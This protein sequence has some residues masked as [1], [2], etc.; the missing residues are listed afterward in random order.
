MVGAGCCVSSGVY[1]GKLVE[2]VII[3]GERVG[4]ITTPPV[5]GMIS[6]LSMF[7]VREFLA[8]RLLPLKYRM[9]ESRDAAKKP[10]I[11]AE[12]IAPRVNADNELGCWSDTDSPVELGVAVGAV[13][14]EVLLSSTLNQRFVREY[15]RRAASQLTYR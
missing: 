5:Q 2:S 8:L 7:S 1:G 10:H 4:L 12:M 6:P 15:Y 13:P 9:P 11:H 3:S 14:D